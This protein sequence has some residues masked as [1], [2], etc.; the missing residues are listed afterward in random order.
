MEVNENCFN[1]DLLLNY[2]LESSNVGRS[3]ETQ[4]AHT[5]VQVSEEDARHVSVSRRPGHPRG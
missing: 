4:C 2:S 5:R 3:G 1:S